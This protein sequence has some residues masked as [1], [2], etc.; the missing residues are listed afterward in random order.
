M[1]CESNFLPVNNISRIGKLEVSVQFA[2]T[3]S[4]PDLFGIRAV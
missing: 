2:L 3:T 4:F 1:L